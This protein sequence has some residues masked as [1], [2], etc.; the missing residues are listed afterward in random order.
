MK[1]IENKECEWCGK[2]F[3]PIRK[4]HRFCIRKCSWEY[5][6]SKKNKKIFNDRICI[7]CN[8]SFTPT[9]KARK[10][11]SKEC[12]KKY[13]KKKKRKIRK[14]KKCL[15]CKNAFTPPRKNQKFCSAKCKEKRY[16]IIKRSKLSKIPKKR[17]KCLFCKNSFIPTGKSQKF[18]FIDCWKKSYLNKRK[19]YSK[20]YYK[21]NRNKINKNKRKRYKEDIMFK[22]NSNIGGRIRCSLKFY[23]LSKNRK[24]YETLIINTLQE[25]KEHLEKN[26]LPGMSWDNYGKNGWEL[27]HIISIA[28]F[29]FKSTNDVEFKYCWSLDNLQPLWR[30]DNIKKGD[31]MMLW[32]KEVN[33]R[34]IWK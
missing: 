14:E 1:K 22:L 19:K 26:F 9:T 15:F 29:R 4:S 24:H 8:N 11:C 16:A 28:F 30:K 20:K 32:G 33:A 27:D 7:E 21:I 31:K 34:D 17:K 3:K 10:F 23:N 5:N 2:D 6:N 12:Y 18:C 25:I 13:Y